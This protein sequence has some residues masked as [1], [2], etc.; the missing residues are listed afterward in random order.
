MVFLEE[1]RS[2]VPEP[3]V[4]LPVVLLDLTQL[5]LELLQVLLVESGELFSVLPL[6]FIQNSVSDLE[7]LPQVFEFVALS[8]SIRDTL[9]LV[10]PILEVL[11]HIH[12]FLENGAE[13]NY[14]FFFF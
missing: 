7:F 6:E 10:E 13:E 8:S 14:F 5:L 12:Q 3:L 2:L 11:H 9:S 1:L 4:L